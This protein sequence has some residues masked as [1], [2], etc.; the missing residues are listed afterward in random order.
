MPDYVKMSRATLGILM[1]QEKILAEPMEFT[2]GSRAERGRALM[3]RK[4][5]YMGQEIILDDSIPER[6][7]LAADVPKV[8]KERFTARPKRLNT[9]DYDQR[10]IHVESAEDI[11]D[12]TKLKREIIF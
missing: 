12:P 6:Q 5:T 11:H 10:E 4:L 7:I 3:D 2:G 1:A 8:G 9:V